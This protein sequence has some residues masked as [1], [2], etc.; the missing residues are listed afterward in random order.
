M[1]AEARVEFLPYAQ[2]RR[3]LLEH[4]M[5]EQIEGDR[6]RLVLRESDS[7]TAMPFTTVVFE[8]G[9][10]GEAKMC[11]ERMGECAERLLHRAHINDFMMMP[12]Q[13]WRPILD[14]IA[15]DLASNE[16]WREVDADAS[17]HQNSREPLVMM[18]RNRGLVRAIID[19][20]TCNGAGPEIDLTIAALDAPVVLEWR[21][22][23]AL[24]LQCSEGLAGGLVQFV[25][26]G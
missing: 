18:A 7:K 8:A 4:G 3:T 16:D 23:G 12:L 21:G 6:L 24:T 14:A 13:R 15:F 2:V 11:R 5:V 10:S 22:R 9:T 19:S 20:L 17:L 25:C 1:S 26:G